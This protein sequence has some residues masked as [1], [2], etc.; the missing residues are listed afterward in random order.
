MGYKLT[1]E[2]L[3]MVKRDPSVAQDIIDNGVLVEIPIISGY[4]LIE[5]EHLSNLNQRIDDIF[6]SQK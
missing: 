2:Q 6:H 3:E 1:P 5:K 4:G